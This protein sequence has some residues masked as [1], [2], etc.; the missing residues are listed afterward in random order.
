[1]G[2]SEKL[3]SCLP[4][5]SLACVSF[6]VP[7][8]S[9]VSVTGGAFCI[10]GARLWTPN[11][12]RSVESSSPFPSSTASEKTKIG[13]VTCGKIVA[14][15]KANRRCQRNKRDQYRETHRKWDQAHPDKIAAKIARRRTRLLNNGGSFTDQ[16]WATLKAQYSYRCLACGRAEPEIKLT[17]DHVIP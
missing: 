3:L 16:E 1:E 17:P 15:H 6:S 9:T 10:L 7:S 14:N 13:C 2:N 4:A 11:N 5:K 12:V 8:T